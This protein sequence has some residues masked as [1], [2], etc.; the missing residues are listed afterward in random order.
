MKEEPSSERIE[1]GTFHNPSVVSYTQ[2]P[3][4][5]TA[6][7]GSKTDKDL[8]ENAQRGTSNFFEL[9]RIGNQHR[10]TTNLFSSSTASGTT[11]S[12]SPLY[13]KNDP[14]SI[15]TS[16]TSFMT[17]ISD[18]HN[19]GNNN[20]IMGNNQLGIDN[21]N[22]NPE[23][24]GVSPKDSNSYGVC[25]K[26]N[27]EDFNET[28]SLLNHNVPSS[29]GFSANVLNEVN[30]TCSSRLPH[31]LTGNIKL[32]IKRDVIH[33][34]IEASKREPHIAVPMDTD[35][36]KG[37]SP[38]ESIAQI[39]CAP[40]PNVQTSKQQQPNSGSPYLSSCTTSP[41]KSRSTSP[42]QA[43]K[44]PSTTS[45]S[46]GNKVIAELEE[47]KVDFKKPTS[48]LTEMLLRSSRE[49]TRSSN[50]LFNFWSD[51]VNSLGNKKSHF[52]STV[53]IA[54]S[55]SS[56]SDGNC[57][58]FS[59]CSNNLAYHL[60]NKKSELPASPR[61]SSKFIFG[62]ECSSNFGGSQESLVLQTNLDIIQKKKNDSM[63]RNFSP[64]SA[65]ET[66]SLIFSNAKSKEQVGYAEGKKSNLS[67]RSPSHLRSKSP[68][69][70]LVVP[71]GRYL[72]Q[73]GG[74][75]STANRKHDSTSNW[76][77]NGVF[78]TSTGTK[79]NETFSKKTSR[80]ENIPD[81]DLNN[82]GNNKM[83]DAEEAW[84]DS[85]TKLNKDWFSRG[86][87][88][89][90]DSSSKNV[91]NRY[92]RNDD[93]I[94][95][96]SIVST[97]LTSLNYHE[98][99]LNYTK[100]DNRLQRANCNVNCDK[101]GNNEARGS[102]SGF[103][104]DTERHIKSSS[105]SLHGMHNYQ[106]MNTPLNALPTMNHLRRLPMSSSNSVLSSP[107]YNLNNSSNK[108][109]FLRS[110]TST[111]ELKNLLLFNAAN[112]KLT[113]S[114]SSTNAT[115]GSA[116]TPYYGGNNNPTTTSVNSGLTAASA[117]RSKMT[118]LR[119][120]MLQ[121]RGGGALTCRSRLLHPPK[122]Q[123]NLIKLDIDGKVND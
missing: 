115:F 16:N 45:S 49:Q 22:F 61:H 83:I 110:N 54:G 98:T 86:V 96:S 100:K 14:R 28:T 47:V 48:L 35:T 119:K 50:D 42:R 63:T 11:Q 33:P 122:S 87:R 89:N 17:N 109:S 112:N 3:R 32:D 75:R 78:P 15:T 19:T 4:S 93:L 21:S 74:S 91:G 120:V 53:A 111:P 68:S 10:N 1:L 104:I 59:D 117:S 107:S 7:K 41:S 71:E 90:E 94:M 85:V 29:T 88:N 60:L 84:F 123:S 69:P 36:V 23:I 66:T 58:D 64:C 40:E 108:A 65:E 67:S 25:L 76:L 57:S 70:S 62:S 102:S 34:I 46:K 8:R 43:S 37:N 95:S 56:S 82:S 13:Y 9:S 99:P 18:I 97:P 5:L 20:N 106:Q 105:P 51:S 121:K 101:S 2:Q 79:A 116:N 113:A 80:S 6:L 73:A 27:Q 39:S 52:G 81:N 30:N 92:Q 24:D 72:R 12:K 31:P 103:N 38:S 118:T 26:F 77:E 114:D 55:K 44:N